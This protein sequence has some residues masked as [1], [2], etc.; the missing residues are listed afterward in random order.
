LRVGPL[1][2]FYEVDAEEAQ[3]INVLAIGVKR[4]NQLFVAGEEIPL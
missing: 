3:V 2:I 1:R 4:G